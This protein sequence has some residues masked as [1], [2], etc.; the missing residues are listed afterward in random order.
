MS[1]EIQPLD[2]ELPAALSDIF[3]TSDSTAALEK[4]LNKVHE[5]EHQIFIFNTGIGIWI[6]RLM[7]IPVIAAGII[8][9]LN[10]NILSVELANSTLSLMLILILMGQIL[11]Q[12]LLAKRA[13]GLKLTRAGFEIQGVIARRKGQ[14]FQSLEG[15]DDVSNTL[16]DEH[17]QAISHRIFGILAILCYLGT[18][19]GS[20]ILK[21]PA[22]W[23]EMLEVN[24]ADPWPFI[25]AMS[26]AIG[27]GL[28]ILVWV[29]AIMDPTKDFDTSQPTG[30]LAT[31]YPS[32]HPTLLTA[33]FS[34]TLLYLME[35]G[36][37]NRWLQHTREIG[38]LSIE[39]TSEVEARER[40]LFL[41][42]LHQEGVLN[43]EE[44]KSELS[45]IFPEYAVDGILNHEVFN[46][47]MIHKLFN[48]MRERNPSFFRT[49]DRLE[50]GFINQLREMR[51]SPFI[52]DCE[53]DREVDSGEAN[54]M[55]F[56]GNT[57]QKSSTYK[58]EV[59]SPG[60]VPEHQSIQILFSENQSIDL[61][62]EDDLKI[63]TEGDNDLIHIMGTALDCG[64]VI[65]LTMQPQ[66]KGNYHT[67]VSL[68]DDKGNILEGK[69]MRTNVSKNISAA[70]KQNAGKAGKAGGLA[71]P[72]L[73]AAP[74]LRKLFGLL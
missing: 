55:I 36:L 30:L 72:I 27:T 41:L 25:L 71:V 24:L 21:P 73:K 43:I 9:Q 54:L 35:P 49:I 3:N 42:H 22:A 23:N 70:L 14:P 46:I 66:K 6:N 17:L 28:S 69:S 40:T 29:A 44:V 13:R 48:L 64:S 10:P 37:A 34:Q 12:L 74:S 65:W 8:Y 47:K 1:D 32:G 2:E 67:H 7:P 52:F 59:H 18:F 39:G 38:T 51:E 15:Y 5:E 57:Q 16:Q 50:H 68:L 11:W 56:L 62:E 60:M 31:Y 53:V 4:K 19:A 33:P 61:P 20:I 45:E 58:I 63:I 26:V